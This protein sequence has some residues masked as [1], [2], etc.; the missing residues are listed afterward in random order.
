MFHQNKGVNQEI[1]HGIQ[2][3]SKKAQGKPRV[4]VKENPRAE[5]LNE[6]REKAVQIR[7]GD[8]KLQEE[9]LL[10]TESID[11]WMHADLVKELLKL[12][13]CGDRKEIS[14]SRK[15][16]K[17]FS[18][19]YNHSTFPGSARNNKQSN[20]T[21]IIV[22]CFTALHRHH[23]F[24]FTNWRSVATLLQARLSAPLF[25]QYLF[26]LYLCVTLW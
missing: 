19:K 1:W 2:G 14:Y 11:Y 17:W 5:L 6:P 24:F 23:H 4:T 25:Q 12:S 7:V 20:Y 13:D 15:K 3:F 8:K 21:H 22:L 10:I 18:R 9:C 26:T 16:E